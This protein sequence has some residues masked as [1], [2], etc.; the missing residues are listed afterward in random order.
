L[1]EQVDYAGEFRVMPPDGAQLWIAAR[2]RVHLDKQGKP[3]QMMGAATDINVRKQSELQI[4]AQR[5]ELALLSRATLLGELGGSLAHEL[6]QPLTAM[7]NNAAAGRRFI[8][9]GHADPRKLDALLEAVVAD[10]RR[11]GDILR[12][13]RDMIRKGDEERHPLDLNAVVVDILR[14]VHSD[15]LRR[16]CT[17]VPE[18]DPGLGVVNANRAQLQQVFLNL[19]MN[20]MEAMDPK[21]V[22]MR[23]IIV[24][25]ERPADG[26]MR[27]SVRDF[28][29]GLPPGDP[30]R[31]FAPF[32]SMKRNG[33][34]LGLAIARSII[35]AHGGR[36]AAANA[37][38]GGAC[39][40]FWLP[41]LPADEAA[42]V[43][44]PQ[45][46]GGPTT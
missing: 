36:I 18:L 28:G 19:I 1:Q 21:P 45:P 17:L 24:R 27:V 29:E 16:H 44:S 13:I 26:E 43:A 39:F 38:G 2:G 3:A 11:A 20:A 46:E 9:K 7:V 12:G 32:F 33:M 35:D 34:G 6:N 37:E 41:A 15:A 23:R 30:E 25:T 5:N 22:E 8:A 40:S 31:V 14:L 10:G 42:E 4:E